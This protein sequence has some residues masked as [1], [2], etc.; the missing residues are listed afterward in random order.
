MNLAMNFFS[1][2]CFLVDVLINYFVEGGARNYPFDE[3]SMLWV[4]LTSAFYYLDLTNVK[5]LGKFCKK[6]KK[7]RNK[8]R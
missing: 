3:K 8:R 2:L 1:F 7:E 4:Y 6:T 5:I